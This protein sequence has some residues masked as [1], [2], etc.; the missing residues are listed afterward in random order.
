MSLYISG[1]GPRQGEY[2]E[3]IGKV[4]RWTQHLIKVCSVC[5]FSLKNSLAL[6]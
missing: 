6:I 3:S 5:I 4:T 2:D 1:D